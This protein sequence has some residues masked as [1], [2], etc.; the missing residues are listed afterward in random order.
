L[1]LLAI[2]AWPETLRTTLAQRIVALVDIDTNDDDG[3]FDAY[4]ELIDVLAS[5]FVAMCNIDD[6]LRLITRNTTAA[7]IAA[8]VVAAT[9]GSSS[10][11]GTELLLML[12]AQP[13]AAR[14][15]VVCSALRVDGLVLRA[16]LGLLLE[17][18]E[19]EW[20]DVRG[21]AIEVL[22]QLEDEQLDIE[23]VT[24]IIDSTWPAVQ[25]VGMRHVAHLIAAGRNIPDLL[26]RLAQHPHRHL[27]RFVL[28]LTSSHLR[29]G[30]L[31]LLRLEPMLRAIVF[32]VRP[33]V[34][35]RRDAFGLML[36]RGLQDEA[37][38]E[39]V[40]TL[41]RDVVSSRTHAVRDAALQT[42]SALVTAWPA[43]ASVAAD[44]NI[45]VDIGAVA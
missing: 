25:D 10:L 29:S 35:V 42:I 11:L 7:A 8:V 28:D 43:H 41:C 38:A 18:A 21:A 40:I 9:P 16:Q 45:V 23:R 2:P 12:A 17:L 19:G 20:D 39:F 1:L 32:D 13:A 22:E 5:S 24:A 33:D 37:Q 36:R 6:A 31:G 44:A 15:A 26:P 30:L 3:R 34:S 27:R 14:R 4:V